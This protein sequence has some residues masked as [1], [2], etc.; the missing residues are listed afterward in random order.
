M[1]QTQQTKR[2]VLTALFTA[3][4]TVCTMALAIPTP[5][6][7]YVNLGDTAVIL[8]AYFL[9]PWFG[10]LAGGLGSALADFLLGYVVYAPA[11]LVI[12]AL[13]AVVVGLLMH[14]VG[15]S[16]RGRVVCGVSAEVV[17]LLGYWLFD[18]W[19]YNNYIAALTTL[20]A[21]GVQAL[22][23]LLASTALVM[24]LERVPTLRRTL[25]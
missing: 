13:M 10:A 4:T 25:G 12:K 19:L 9:G 14:W 20:S 1:F 17:M 3:M 15:T 22:F 23:G 24:T 16:L 7:G 18:G 11:T 6:G 8:G 2:W 21:N 5:T